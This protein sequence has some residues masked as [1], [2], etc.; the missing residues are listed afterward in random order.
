MATYTTKYETV[1]G[2]T[3]RAPEGSVP[4][5]KEPEKTTKDSEKKTESKSE[6]KE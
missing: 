2:R 3:R 5:S 4:K 6:K 1:N